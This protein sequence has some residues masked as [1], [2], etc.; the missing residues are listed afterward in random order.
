MR[1]KPRTNPA[2]SEA[3]SQLRVIGGQ[4]RSR[5]LSFPT[6]EGLRPTPDRVRE[7]LFNWLQNSVPGANCLDLFAGSG[8]LGIEALSR[9]AAHCN[10]IDINSASCKTLKENLIL[11]KCQD[12]SVSQSDTTQWL[13]HQIQINNADQFDLVFLDPPFNKGLC[14]PLCEQLTE[15]NL[16]ST[17]AYVYVETELNVEL[18]TPWRLHR[19][20]RSGQVHY[21]LYQVS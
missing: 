20:K 2:R 19:E 4:W 7:T 11:L 8:A 16:L 13:K 14:Q 18:I 15:S 5:K 9:G 3:L 17:R 10:F 21:R 1:A 6:I 12:G